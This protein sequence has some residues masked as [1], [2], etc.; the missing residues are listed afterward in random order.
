M[1]TRHEPYVSLRSGFGTTFLVHSS[2]GES[3]DLGPGRH[4]LCF[5]SA[6][7]AFVESPAKAE[8]RGGNETDTVE[9]AEAQ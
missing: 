2:T 8:P 6:G 1:E 9:M 7:K 5:N 4:A 3:V